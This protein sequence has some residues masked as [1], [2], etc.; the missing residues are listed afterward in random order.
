MIKKLSIKKTAIFSKTWEEFKNRH[1]ID[2]YAMDANDDDLTGSWDLFG[3]TYWETIKGNQYRPLTS[4]KKHLMMT[5]VDSIYTNPGKI[6]ME[7]KMEDLKDM[8]L[9]TPMKVVDEAIAKERAEYDMTPNL[10][11]TD[12]RGRPPKRKI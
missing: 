5:F 3:E 8:R 4:G 11:G 2:F 1:N 6:P 7:Q 10:P 9:E 12:P